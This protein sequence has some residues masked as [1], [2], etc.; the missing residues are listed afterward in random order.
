MSKFMKGLLQKGLVAAFVLTL[1]ISVSAQEVIAT[2][3][4]YGAGFTEYIWNAY[5]GAGDVTNSY[6]FVPAGYN[7]SDATVK[8]PVIFFFPGVGDVKTADKNSV[9]RLGLR[10]IAVVLEGGFYGP[11]GFNYIV[12]GMQGSAGSP[13]SEYAAFMENYAFVKYRDKIDFSRVYLTGLSMGG[14]RIMEYM[15]DPVRASK[16]AAIAPVA[17]GTGCPYVSGCGPGSTYETIV[18]NML[19]NPSLGMFFSHNVLDPTVTYEVSKGYVDG[20]NAVQPNRAQFYFD[21]TN[22]NHDAW[23]MAYSPDTR[24]FGTGKNM[25]EWFLQFS[26]NITLPATFTSFTAGLNADKT[27]TVRWSTGAEQNNAYFA[28]ERSEDG[29]DYKEIGRVAGA[30]NSSVSRQYQF[31]DPKPLPGTNYYRLKQVDRNNAFQYTAIR[32]I[33]MTNRGLDIMAGPNPFRGQLDITAAGEARLPLNVRI[34]DVNGRTLRNVN[35]NKSGERVKH[36][37]DLSPLAPGVY[38][39]QVSGDQVLFQQKLIKNQ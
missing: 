39:V 13:A 8:Y 12:I 7:A 24:H 28:V 9:L 27:I 22:P 18:N 38:I 4:N 2:R 16:I 20:V 23:S 26:L 5:T 36:T 21:P 1:C 15:A 30:G 17:T 37:L 10:A 35:F 29:K 31:K 25:Y 11:G 14:G 34:T 6:E 19:N 33:I 32:K 3:T